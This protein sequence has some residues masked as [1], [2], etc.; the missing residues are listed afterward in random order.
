MLFSL[1]PSPHHC[2]KIMRLVALLICF[3]GPVL[4]PLLGQDLPSTTLVSTRHTN[5][6]P[7]PMPLVEGT[8]DATIVQFVARLLQHQHYLQMPVNDDVSS[9]FLDRYVDSW[10]NLHI[11][12]LQSDVQ[13]FEKYR[14]RLD[15]LTV[16]EGDTTAARVIFTR[17]R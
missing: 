16:N 13:E 8:K 2:R 3:A 14:Y 11:Y 17:F 7:A 12:F 10:D 5:G 1:S 6:I 9:K 15:D 4:T